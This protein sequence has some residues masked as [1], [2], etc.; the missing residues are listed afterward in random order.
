MKKS[1]F[2]R[3]KYAIYADS[4]GKCYFLFLY[5]RGKL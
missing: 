1:N 3:K 2:Y 4:V 5:K